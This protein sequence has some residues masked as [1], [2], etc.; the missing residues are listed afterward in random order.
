MSERYVVKNT[1]SITNSALDCPVQL[2]KYQILFDNLLG[3]Q[4][5]RVALTCYT[6]IGISKTFLAVKC[7]DKTSTPIKTMDDVAISE[8][9]STL[10]GEYG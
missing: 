8:Q 5:L 10:Y 6:K 7:L 3:K 4:F 2:N 1:Q 9:C